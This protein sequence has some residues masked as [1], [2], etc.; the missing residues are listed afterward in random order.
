[1]PFG[2]L[3]LRLLAL[4]LLHLLC[5][6][7]RRRRCEVETVWA[8]RTAVQLQRAWNSGRGGMRTDIGL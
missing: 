7:R 4:L 5:C 6:R 2:L 3:L 1:M 8:I